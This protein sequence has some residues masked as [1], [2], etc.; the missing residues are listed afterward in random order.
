MK[1][2]VI[3]ALLIFAT[4]SSAQTTPPD[5]LDIYGGPGTLDGKFQTAAGDPDPQGWVGIDDSAPSISGRWSVATHNAANL[6]PAIP[7]NHA[8]W[9]GEYISA[10]TPEDSAWG[11]GNNWNEAIGTSRSIDPTRATTI[12]LT[13]ILNVD[14]EPGYD[15]LHVEMMTAAGPVELIAFDGMRTTASLNEVRTLLPGDY[16]GENGDE[17][18]IRLRVT[19]DEA[20]SD[21][22]CNWPTAGAVQ[23]DNLTLGI[24]QPELPPYPDEIETCEPGDPIYWEQLIL[25]ELGAGNFAQLWTG[26]DDMDPDRDNPSPQWAFINDGII[27]PWLSPSYCWVKCYGPDSLSIYM[28]PEAL[29][30]SILSPPIAL[31]DGWEGIP[32]LAFDA[33]HDPAECYAVGLRWAMQTTSDP[34]GESG[35][36]E[37]WDNYVYTDA[38]PV[39][40][41]WEFACDQ[42]MVPA[43]SRFVRIK[44]Q[45]AQFGI[46]CWGP[47]DSP[48]PYLDNVRLQLA[49]PPVSSTPLPTTFATSAA[50]NP[51]NPAVVIRW[52]LPRDG[53]LAVRIHDA[54]GR[55]VRTLRDDMAVAGP[56]RITWRGR[57]DAGQRA[58]AGVYFCRIATDAGSQLLKLTLLK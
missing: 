2:R 41:R 17:V 37:T 32:Q 10:C 8:W 4:T 20:W 40:R 18:Q 57:D 39:Y 56:G 44:L 13:G 48:A 24:S 26:L 31:P 21:E 16:V 54:R 35:W 25:P 34:L 22:D 36:T 33:Y 14:I 27:V 19:S 29:R 28:G 53:K 58:A 50:P 55:L 15:Y 43:D 11:Y 1:Y 49:P 42:D 45:A 46:L 3:L 51:F 12:T 52:N 30:S 5:T 7:D 47:M 38:G 23:A 6:D 9:C